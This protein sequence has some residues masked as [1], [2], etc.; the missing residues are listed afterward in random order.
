MRVFKATYTG[1]RGGKRTARRLYVEFRQGER[2]RRL[3]GFTDKGATEAMGRKVERLAELREAGEPLPLDLVRFVEVLPARMRATL[4]RWGVLDPR[5]VASAQ[6]LAEHVV[7]FE[8]SLRSRERSEDHVSLTVARVKAVLEGTGATM[9]TD[10]R[11]EPVERWLHAQRERGDREKGELG[12]SARSSNG[13]LQA[14][15]QFSRWLCSTGR[16][17]EDP[18]RTLRPLN[19]ALDRRLERRAFSD[20]ELRS[21]LAAAVAGP[22]C[23]DLAGPER[24]LLYR[25]AAETGL[26]ANELRSLRAGDFE[27]L[28]GE[29]PTVRVAAQNSKRRREDVLPLRRALAQ[30]VAE[31]M[32]GRLPSALAFSA[33]PSKSADMLREDLKAAKIEP[34]DECGRVLDFHSL[35]V[36]FVTA[37]ARAGVAP[38]VAQ[39][40]ARHSSPVLTFNVYAKLGADDERAALSALPNLGPSSESTSARATGTDGANVLAS[41]LASASSSTVSACPP[42]STSRTLAR[43]PRWRNRQTRRIQNP[44]PA[45]E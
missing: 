33:V 27:G 19:A 32:R 43:R 7:A 21:L 22:E 16:T 41:S 3:P 4:A 42:E 1:R 15:R 10:L 13:Y 36:S 45:R 9:P 35:R 30:A 18:L 17:S 14:V 29:R 28:D 39:A 24:A 8:E 12:L 31:H 26:R 6:P 23:F 40:L 34:E 37:L 20:D 25:V 11:P 2:V 44:F 38:K 5:T